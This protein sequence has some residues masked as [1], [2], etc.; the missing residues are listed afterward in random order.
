M[1]GKLYLRNANRLGMYIRGIKIKKEVPKDNYL[2]DLDV[3]KNLKDIGEL[4]FKKP[5]TFFVGENGIGKSTLIEAIAINFGF[6]PEGGTRNY[7]FKTKNTHSDLYDYITVIKTFNHAKNGYF[8][9]A[10]SFYNTLS[11]LDYLDAEQYSDNDYYRHL[12]SNVGHGASMHNM[13]HGESFLNA[14][15]NFTGNGLYI[16]DEP[17][18][19]LSPSGI[20]K[21]ILIIQQLVNN[22]SQFVISTHSPIL[23]TCP[24]SDVYEITKNSISL[25]NY[26]DTM[27]FQ[28]TRRFLENP[29]KMLSRLLSE[30]E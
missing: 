16:L 14:I 22:K 9:R 4:A 10:E 6:N 23:L 18:S 26:K 28:I 19:A 2:S 15:E 21:L 12:K 25:V 1:G 20:M 27:H 8:L 7:N 17:E 5:V 13:S 30:D 24:H 11:Y 29:E 3:V